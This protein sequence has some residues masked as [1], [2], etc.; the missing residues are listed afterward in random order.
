MEHVCLSVTDL[1]VTLNRPLWRPGGRN[2]LRADMGR[3]STSDVLKQEPLATLI[4][5]LGDVLSSGTDGC[6]AVGVVEALLL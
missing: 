3:R 4:N 6:W 2:C 1:P 5:N